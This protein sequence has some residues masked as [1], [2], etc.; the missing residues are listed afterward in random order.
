MEVKAVKY[1]RGKYRHNRIEISTGRN[2]LQFD[3]QH[4]LYDAGKC[5]KR[6]VNYFDKCRTLPDP[7]DVQ[8]EVA[9]SS[10]SLCLG[11]PKRPSKR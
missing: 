8:P 11:T 2:R 3:D 4:E 1:E 6:S 10:V 9:T 5:E 7:A